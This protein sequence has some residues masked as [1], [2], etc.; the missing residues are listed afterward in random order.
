MRYLSWRTKNT[1]SVV[2]SRDN[3][4]DLST[5]QPCDDLDHSVLHSLQ[6][7]E[8]VVA[9][10]ATLQAVEA[11]VTVW[12]KQ[13]RQVRFVLLTLFSV[14]EERCRFTVLSC[15]DNL[16]S[17]PASATHA[18]SSAFLVVVFKLWCFPQRLSVFVYCSR[19]LALYSQIFESFLLITYCDDNVFTRPSSKTVWVADFAVTLIAFYSR[20]TVGREERAFSKVVYY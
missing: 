17:S 13:I 11:S 1:W 6:D 12:I 14:R 16:I 20:C 19:S 9:N 4:S 5:L 2:A 8:Q 15:F 7:Y 18:I 10:S 3:I